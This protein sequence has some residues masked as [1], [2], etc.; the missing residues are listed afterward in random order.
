MKKGYFISTAL[1]V[2]F[3]ASVLAQTSAPPDNYGSGLKLDLNQEGT[4]FVRMIMWHQFW[5]TYN[6]NNPGTKDING[7]AQSSSLDLGI[8][9]SR[10]LM[11]AQLSPRFLILTDFGINNVSFING[12]SAGILGT[13]ASAAGQGG[14]RPQLYL[15]DAWTEYAIFK[16]KLHIGTGLHYWN[17]VSRLS[18]ASTLNFMTMDAPIF[19]WY[20]IEGTD[21]FARQ[22]GV[23]AKGQ[24]GR[25]DYRVSVNK[26]YAFGVSPAKG[27]I[28]PNGYAVNALNEKASF[29]GYFNWAFK[30]K[31]NNV[32]PFF[33]G[34]YLGKKEVL[35]IGAGFYTQA[36]VTASA[37]LAGT[38][39]LIDKYR[40]NC[41]GVDFY[42][43]RPINKAKGTAISI[44]SVYYNYDFGPGYLRNIG[45]LNLHTNAVPGTESFNGAGNAQ[46]TIGTGSIWYTQIGYKFAN[47]KNGTSFM[48]YVT[49]TYKDFERL[50]KASF[51]YDLG[52]NYFISNHN[53]K[54]TLQY[55]NRPLYILDATGNVQRDGSKGE[56][57]LQTHIFL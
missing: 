28:T 22:L 55:S 17:G 32:L 34:T 24:L 20:N 46:P 21:Q 2:C 1:S 3:S 26:P 54:V 27:N 29:S 4:K 15:H 35:N 47:F 30:D 48:P 41:F 53:A 6:Q 18:S 12:G 31:E 25:F 23:Y 50:G 38:D 42:W 11:Y 33:V 19:N 51:Q 16:D 43:D 36:D 13:G 57:I 52:L 37:R 44:Y 10:L 9:R 7:N 5:A 8:R 40:Q 56:F 39:T 14:K 45:I 49:G